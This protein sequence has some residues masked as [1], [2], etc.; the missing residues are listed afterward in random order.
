MLV[1][2][3]LFWGLS[4]PLMRTWQ[5][6][7]KGGPS[8]P[9]TTAAG[10]HSVARGGSPG[11]KGLAA[12]TLIALRMLLALAVLATCRPQLFLAPS[13]REHGT[14]TVIGCAFF[15]GFSLQVVGLSWITPALSALITS[16]A[17]A[18]VPLLALACFRTPVP[19]LTL[20]GLGLGIGGVAVLTEMDGHNGRSLGWGEGLTLLASVFFAVQIVLLDR[21]GRRTR[22]AHLTVGFLGVTGLSALVIAVVW[23]ATTAQ[24]AAWL[25]WVASMLGSWQIVSDVALLTLLSTVLAFHWMNTYQP[26]VSAGR[27]A[28]IYLLEPVFAAMFSVGMGHEEL[29]HNLLLGGG[30]VL[31]GNLLV[32]VPAR[33]RALRTRRP[34]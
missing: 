19:A 22:S 33:L 26:R 8:P 7:A 14:G 2:V 3:T 31:A 28:L 9:G 1:L 15:L 5:Q 23:A 12:L 17:C 21:L 30:L 27:A 13:R 32:E 4:F 10:D 29:T 20:L 6:E 25:A 18:W 16:L 11:G 34:G 24:L